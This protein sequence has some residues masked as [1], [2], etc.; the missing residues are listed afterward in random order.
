MMEMFKKRKYA[1]PKGTISGRFSGYV[2]QRQRK[3]ADYLNSRTRHV[4]AAAM[5]VGLIV[6]CALFG[7]YLL[8][9]LA[10]AFGAFN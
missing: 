9:L 7:G 10:N 4:S 6:F 8:Y 1:D 2:G 5:L 3:L